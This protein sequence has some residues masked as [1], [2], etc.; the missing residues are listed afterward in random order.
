[1]KRRKPVLIVDDGSDS[2]KAVNLLRE[3][4]IEFVPYDIK[5][6]AES[7][8]GDLPTTKAPSVF[9]PEGVFKGLNGVV[10][11]VASLTLSGTKEAIRSESESAYW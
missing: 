1:M 9:A 6:F 7:C 5:K 2:L 11:Y 8:C 10:E 3:K 4:G